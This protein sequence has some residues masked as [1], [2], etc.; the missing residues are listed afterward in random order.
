VDVDLDG[1][2]AVVLALQLRLVVV[3]FG[4]A[5]QQLEMALLDVFY[6]GLLFVG[7]ERVVFDQQVVARG[8]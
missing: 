4:L 7:D 5:S 2:L 8:L 3:D 6:Q 1:L